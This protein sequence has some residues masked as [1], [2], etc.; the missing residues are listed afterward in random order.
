ML[1]VLFLAAA[2]SLFVPQQ[3]QLEDGASN[4]LV[5]YDFEEE[6]VE[7]GPYTLM[8]FDGAKGSVSLS[9]LY[10]YSGYRSVEI[11]DIAGD[12]QFAELQGFFAD[13]W[14]GYLFI[15]F[16]MLIV[17]TEEPMNIAFAGNAHFSMSEH[18]LAIWLK[19]RR[20]TLYQV[21]DGEDVPLFD[22][23]PFTWYVV[24]ISYNVDAG[25]YDLLV[26]AE[27]QD[28]PV[29]AL[30]E[31]VNAVGIP[32]SGLRKYSFI[33]DL[34]GRDRSNAWFYI[35]DIAITNDIPVSETPFVAPGRR[36]LFVD[37]YDRYLV[38]LYEKPGCA[39]VLAYADFGFAST[40]LSELAAAGGMSLLTD[41]DVALKLTRE[42]TP[43]LRRRLSAMR[44]WRLGCDAPPEAL[45]L[46]RRAR[47]K[48]PEGKIYAMSEVLALARAKKWPE[49][50]A[51]L[52]DIYPLWQDDPRFPALSATIGIARQ[53]LESAEQWLKASAESSTK[54]FTHE[55]VKRLWSGDIG[56]GLADALKSE[57][58]AEWPALISAALSAD[59]RFYVFLWQK[60]YNEA[61]LY[62][63]RMASLFERM[64][65][66]TGRWLERQGDA[67]F[68][69]GD[70]LAAQAHYEAS[71]ES[72][73]DADSIWLKLSDVHFALGN[74]ELERLYRE[75][76]YGSLR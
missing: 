46:F 75:K 2:V 41:A 29:V 13:K 7:T 35:D 76:I 44:D 24:D 43:F 54:A 3:P 17:E 56:P 14:H 9:S 18:G 19:L 50:D 42:L 1:P 45:E 11:K 72:R 32:G 59:L 52:L 25:T 38:R 70:L 5:W 4:T 40:D 8:V 53:D 21:S 63:E 57:F 69:A 71:A 68:Y 20:G 67:A 28:D 10:R 58:P 16:A 6:G 48:A 39:P 12:G 22:V 15:H 73:E 51:L 61:Q 36:M 31:Q 60:R 49:A 47:D 26:H 33:G 27:G 55:L 34:P 30:A 65:L 37:M 74:L 23:E 62:A 64:K 66:P